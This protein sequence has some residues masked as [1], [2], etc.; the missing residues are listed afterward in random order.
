VNRLLITGSTGFIGV[1]CVRLAA[2]AYEVHA[3]GR[4]AAPDLPAGVTFHRCDLLAPGA[5]ARLVETVRPTHLLH[6][7]WVVTPGVCWESP[8]NHRWSGV[9]RELL[10]AFARCGG[11][12]AVL[13]GSCAEYDWSAAGVCREDQTPTRPHTTY[14]RC[15]RDL[16]LWASSLGME[17]GLSV[18]SARLFW[19]YGPGEH[20]ARLVPAVARALLAG[21]PVSCTSGTQVRD[22]LHVDDA[23]AALVSLVGC[24]VTGPLNVGSGEPV[25]V[26]EVVGE[27]A[28]V[29]GRPELVRLGERP[30]PA[31]EPPLIVADVSRLRE[32][33]GWRPRIRLA[34]GVQSTV[35]WWKA[36]RQG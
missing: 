17:R 10:L 3:A 25:A 16:G 19:L 4:G 31:C 28:R 7:A 22:F 33:V 34:A 18:A 21:V 27:V 2:A 35:D 15:K 9:S 36:T 32:A 5:A 26:R 1:P 8:E 30:T 24:R 29:C 12:R 20:P 14:G 6:I 23:A 13:A 11:S